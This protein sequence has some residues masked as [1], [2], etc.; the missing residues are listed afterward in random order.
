MEEIQQRR[1]VELVSTTLLSPPTES[2]VICILRVE[3][4]GRSAIV[5]LPRPQL[6]LQMSMSRATV[7]NKLLSPG[8]N[9]I[10][11]LFYSSLYNSGLICLFYCLTVCKVLIGEYPCLESSPHG[12]GLSRFE[13][14]HTRL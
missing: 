12:Y 3:V 2:M 10:P 7:E 4:F 11:T 14:L 9:G 8:G 13:G 1:N 5:Q 6:T